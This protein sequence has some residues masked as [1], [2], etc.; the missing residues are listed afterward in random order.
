MT[1]LS[2][3]DRWRADGTITEGQYGDIREWTRTDRLSVFLELNALL[4]LGV[5]ACAAG[6]GW[7]VR[8]HFA[9]LGDV[10]VLVPL[11]MILAACLGYCF[12]RASPYS[13]AAVPTP[14]FAFDYILYLGCLVFAVELG[15]VE[16]RFHLLRAHWDQYLLASAI[17]YFA[18]AFRFDNRFVLSL[19]LATLGSWFGVHVTREGLFVGDVRAWALVYGVIVALAGV[20]LNRVGVKRHFLETCFHV[21]ANVL[22]LAMASGIVS[23]D[24]AVRWMWTIGVAVGAGVSIAQGIRFRRFA[25]VVYGAMYG[26]AGLMIRA[27]EF[28][29][30]AVAFLACLLVSSGAVIVA[31]AAVARRFGRQ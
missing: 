11:T 28:V 8:V 1:V 31:L 14:T 24:P 22:L 23:G 20:G 16:F 21:A 9:R 7:T 2:C 12:S 19:A 3:L 10:F 27:S 13:R 6:I 4:Y 26:Y 25:F 30:G 5:L 15:Y 17:V 29:D 18:L